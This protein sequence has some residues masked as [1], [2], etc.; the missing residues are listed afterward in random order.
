[1][2]GALAQKPG[3]AGC[4]SDD[5]TGGACQDGRALDDARGVAASADGRSVYVASFVADAVAVF[6]PAAVAGYSASAGA[7]GGR[8]H[9]GPREVPGAP[10][11]I[12]ATGP[13]TRGT[14]RRD[15]IVGRAGRDLIRGLG[16]NDLICGR[17]GR[18]L[19][20][21]GAG[22]D[23]LFG[24]GG[25][26]RLLGGRGRDRLEGGPGRD[27]CLGVLGRDRAACETRRGL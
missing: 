14:P 27:S 2:T 15:V 13:R 6:D 11:T 24:G 9:A 5:G 18:D 20:I 25:A 12:L 16:G 1:M 19:L 10:A 23:L 21:G 3:A 26:D 7:R 22:A 8:R 4:V 17:G